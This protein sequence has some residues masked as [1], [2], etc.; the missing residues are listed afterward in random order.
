MQNTSK[1]M[2]LVCGLNE[3]TRRPTYCDAHTVTMGR[4]ELDDKQRLAFDESHR[5]DPE[6][7][8]EPLL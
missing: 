8:G 2:P 7:S 3:T 4:I 5:I 6:R 1:M